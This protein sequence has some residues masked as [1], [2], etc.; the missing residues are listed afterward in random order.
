MPIK[1]QKKDGQTEDFDRN[2]ILNGVIKSGGTPEEAENVT[3]QIEAWIVTAAINGVIPSMQIRTKLLEVLR[4]VNP[5]AAAA[6]ETYQKPS[7]P[8]G[9]VPPESVPPAPEM[10]PTEA[11]PSAPPTL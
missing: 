4:L 5:T 11:P 8:I 7:E 3:K 1:V 6:F 2:K 9:S 10:P